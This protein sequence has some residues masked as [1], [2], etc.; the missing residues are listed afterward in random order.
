[1]CARHGLSVTRTFDILDAN[2]VA[3]HTLRCPVQHLRPV[4]FQVITAQILQGQEINRPSLSGNGKVDIQ[5]T[6]ARWEKHT[7]RHR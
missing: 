1:M 6:C 5:V 7:P 3:V 4:A 2:G